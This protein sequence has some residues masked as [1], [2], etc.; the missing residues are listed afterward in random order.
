MNWR[1]ICAL[2]IRNFKRT[3]RD[4]TEI[5]WTII[6]PIFMM[7]LTAYVFIPPGQ[8][9]VSIDL[10][11]VNLDGNPSGYNFT[12]ARLVE[13]MDSIKIDGKKLFNIK[14]VDSVEEGV[15]RLKRGELDAL[16]VIP[17]GFSQNITYSRAYLQVYISGADIRLKQIAYAELSS[18]FERVIDRTVEIRLAYLKNYTMAYVPE[19]YRGYY[20]EFFKYLTYT[21]EP[22]NVTFNTVMP[23]S[24]LLYTS[25]SPRDLS[26]SRMPSS[27]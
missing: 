24:C 26:T 21:I 14:T 18:F 13:I 3:L 22:L 5:F 27:A 23:E 16:L 9:V 6:F 12:G 4:K 2:S 1:A 20:E 8:G 11:V 10:G 17:K 7:T 19:E 25:P 15:R